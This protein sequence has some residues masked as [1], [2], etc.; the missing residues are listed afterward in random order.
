MDT[1]LLDGKAAALQVRARIKEKI[2]AEKEKGK[3]A[4][5]LVVIIVGED[6][7]S[8]VYVRNKEK[9][10]A[11]VGIDSVI[12]RMADREDKAGLQADILNTI[13]KLNNDDTV[14]GLLVQLPLP[15]G[16]DERFI[17]DSIAPEKDVDG[18]H[19]QNVGLLAKGEIDGLVSCTPAGIIELLKQNKIEMDGKHVVIAGRSNIVGKPLSYL[20]LAHDATVTVCHS[21]TKD[22]KAFTQNADIFVS[23]IGKPHFFDASFIKE[24]AAVV[25]VGIHR[26]ENGLIGDV[27]TLS[28]MDKASCITPV[29]GG[30]GPMTVAMLMDNTFKAY[31]KK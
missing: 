31:L 10:C 8:E 5:R 16:L 4:P 19:P 22:L 6:P 2:A 1:I 3:R 11:D 18:F 26:T 24:G 7:A 12:V 28:C 20:F 27:D 15:K 17:T 9:A 14:D 21:H 29:P 30:V 23:A 13:R 25:D